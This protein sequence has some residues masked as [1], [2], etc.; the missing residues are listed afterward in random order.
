VRPLSVSIL[1]GRKGLT[2]SQST[3]IWR[4]IDLAKIMLPGIEA[5]Q[6]SAPL[7]LLAI[8]S[9]CAAKHANARSHMMKMRIILRIVP[10]AR[11]KF[12]LF[13]VSF[14]LSESLNL[15]GELFLRKERNTLV[16]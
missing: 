16:A 13:W 10:T 3:K 5:T 4:V 6:L 15:R 14:T 11:T 1:K 2:F 9:S 12:V 8:W 7:R